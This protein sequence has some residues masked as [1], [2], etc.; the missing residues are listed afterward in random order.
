VLLL[1]LLRYHYH[2]PLLSL[3][4]STLSVFSLSFSLFSPPLLHDKT[5]LDDRED[6]DSVVDDR[7]SVVSDGDNDDKGNS[8][9]VDGDDDDFGNSVVGEGNDGDGETAEMVMI[10]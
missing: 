6:G 1:L 5:P 3:S 7:N 2:H 10:C 4:F 9:G 8:V